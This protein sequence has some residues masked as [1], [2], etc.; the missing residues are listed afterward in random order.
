MREEPRWWPIR[1]ERFSNCTDV[2]VSLLK[3]W[4]V[5]SGRDREQQ[6]SL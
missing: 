5:T 6:W 3:D 4:K 1:E 2:I